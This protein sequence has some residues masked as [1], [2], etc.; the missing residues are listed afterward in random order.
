MYTDILHSPLEVLTGRNKT[1]TIVPDTVTDHDDH[2]H[3]E[4]MHRCVAKF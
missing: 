1:E 3:V 4:A 2:G